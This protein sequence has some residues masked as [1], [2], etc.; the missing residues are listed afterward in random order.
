M[1]TV[2]LTY[3]SLTWSSRDLHDGATCTTRRHT[4]ASFEANWET[5]AQLAST[6]SKP[7]DLNVCPMPSH[8]PVGFKVQPTNR[9]LFS[10]EAQTK[11]LS[12]QF[13][14]TNHQ[15]VATDF[16]A[17]TGKPEPL[18]LR[19]NLE[20]PSPPVLRPNWRKPSPPVLSPNRRK[21]SQW[22]WCQTTDKPS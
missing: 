9:S 4:S 22:F 11:K 3:L 19:L 12:Q 13:W 18:V 8:P 21:P 1:Q 16:E 10:F 20:K 14:G 17:Q 7:L 15:I 6:W 5:L 2:A